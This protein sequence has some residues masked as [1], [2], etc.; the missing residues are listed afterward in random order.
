MS[1]MDLFD[2]LPQD[3]EMVAKY[4]EFTIFYAKPKRLTDI[5]AM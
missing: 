3:D 4:I 2:L 5:C 1:Q